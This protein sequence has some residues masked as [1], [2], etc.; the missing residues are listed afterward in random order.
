MLGV[1]MKKTNKSSLKFIDKNIKTNAQS[2]SYPV[3]KLQD[4]K[5][6]E[7]QRANSTELSHIQTAK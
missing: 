5:E 2:L 1:V 4:Y 6:L 3:R 7:K